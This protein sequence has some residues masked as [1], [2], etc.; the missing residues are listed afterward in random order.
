[1][2]ELITI[3]KKNIAKVFEDG[4]TDYLL[5]IISDEVCGHVC[6]VTTLR[7]RKEIASLAAKISRSK[8]YLD[9]IGKS[10]VAEL[11][12]KPKLVDAERKRMRDYLDDLKETIRSPLSE[13][14]AAEEARASQHEA[15][16]AEIISVGEYALEHWD[17]LLLADMAN[18]RKKIESELIDACWEEY[19]LEANQAKEQAISN[20]DKAIAKRTKYDEE[21]AEL[22][23]LRL[24]KSEKEQ[25]DRDEA[26]RREG[27][28]RAKLELKEKE[29][30]A[31]QAKADAEQRERDAVQ[32]GELAK[33]NAERRAKEAVEQA[34]KR[35]EIA[36]QAERDRIEAEQNAEKEASARREA[37]LQHRGKI[38]LEIEER[39]FE[40]GLSAAQSK[41]VVMSI[42]KNEIPFIKICY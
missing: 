31:M 13:W 6:D 29:R 12:A 27:E 26:M 30:A 5:K 17:D 16:I 41:K 18:G 35:A 3:E 32:A 40:L 36:A 38:N 37:N 15:K 23:K 39:L 19:E 34:N 24:M 10:Y 33:L 14:E 22:E 9:G 7:G 11:K 2:N 21:Q 25:K 28:E 8:T 1:M 42:A 20:L 4:G